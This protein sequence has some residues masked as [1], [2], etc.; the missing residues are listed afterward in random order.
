MARIWC[1][2]LASWA[3]TRWRGGTDRRVAPHRP[4]SPK[5]KVPR[6]GIRLM[7]ARRVRWRCALWAPTRRSP[8]G[9]AHEWR[10]GEPGDDPGP[11]APAQAGAHRR[12]TAAAAAGRQQAGGLLRRVAPGPAGPGTERQTGSSRGDEDDD[13]S[14]PV[15]EEPGELRLQVS[16][17][18]RA[19]GDP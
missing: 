19:E 6:S 1:A 17:L 16:A 9:R 4:G 8:P 11:D 2:T 18:H 10:R 7:S 12:G 3:S 14:L 13:G 15:P 5:P